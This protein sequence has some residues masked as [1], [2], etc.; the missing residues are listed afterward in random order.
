MCPQGVDTGSSRMS[1]HTGHRNWLSVTEILAWA[2]APTVAPGVLVPAPVPGRI[3]SLLRRGVVRKAEVP[4]RDVIDMEIGSSPSLVPCLKATLAVKAV[5]G[6]RSRFYVI[7]WPKKY[8]KCH[9][10]LVLYGKT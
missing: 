2:M 10:S 3:V 8:Y 6:L 4:V 9:C 7:V 5:A 1:R